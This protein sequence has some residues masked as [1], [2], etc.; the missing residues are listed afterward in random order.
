MPDPKQ[1]LLDSIYEQISPLMSEA[2]IDSEDLRVYLE[3]KNRSKCDAKLHDS[4]ELN[5]A[6][7]GKC[8]RQVLEYADNTSAS[9]V[10]MK[11]YK[12]VSSRSDNQF[13]V[14]CLIFDDIPTYSFLYQNDRLWRVGSYFLGNFDMNTIECDSVMITDLVKYEEISIGEYNAALDSY[15]DKLKKLEFDP[16][17]RRKRHVAIHKLSDN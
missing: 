13:R 16:D 4:V 3:N 11:Y 6:L 9:T 2:G 17:Y 10:H 14:T 15:I 12:V 1:A 7:V 8:Y 5:D